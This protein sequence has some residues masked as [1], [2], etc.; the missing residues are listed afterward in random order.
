MNPK[1][2][3]VSEGTHPSRPTLVS[4]RG[5]F[6]LSSRARAPISVLPQ[7]PHFGPSN[8]KVS[9]SFPGLTSSRV[10][11]GLSTAKDHGVLTTGTLPAFPVGPTAAQARL[12]LDLLN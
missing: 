7:P 4:P 9:V 6:L 10:L 2:E 12:A 3:Q 5:A 11:T 8:T 1:P